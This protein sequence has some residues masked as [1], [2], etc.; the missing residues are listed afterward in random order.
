MIR[1]PF[2]YV[3]P[4]SVEDAVRYKTDDTVSVIGGGTMLIPSMTLG[5]WAPS[6]LIDTRHLPIRAVRAVGE[7]LQIGAAAS[8][9]TVAASSEASRLAPLIGKVCEGITGGPQLTGQAS[10]GGSVCFG[11]PASEAPGCLTALNARMV[12]HSVGGERSVE[13]SDFFLGPFKTARRPD[14]MLTWIVIPGPAPWT[15]S[16]YVK[17]KHSTSSWPI[18]TIS[19]VAD[20]RTVRLV[21]GA[22]AT[23]PVIVELAMDG[24]DPA[25]LG[26]LAS[27]AVADGLTEPWSDALASGDYRRRV[28]PGLAARTVVRAL[29]KES[30][31]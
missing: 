7:D 22:A 11:N 9:D 25:S 28:A 23:R 3:A 20:A 6:R 12:L 16:A 1:H 15:R 30:A 17:Q 18:V 14:E 19:V 21:V 2:D 10:F 24:N 29:T 31:A 26:K 13:A 27:E 4:K 5:E 8:Y